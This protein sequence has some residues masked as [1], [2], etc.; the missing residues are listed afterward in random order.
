MVETEYRFNTTEGQEYHNWLKSLSYV[1][2]NQLFPVE[3][4]KVLFMFGKT[5]IGG[6]VVEVVKPKMEVRRDTIW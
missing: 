3:W 4:E 5:I 6:K 1:S 2:F